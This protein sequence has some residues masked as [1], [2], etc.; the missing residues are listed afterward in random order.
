MRDDPSEIFGFH[1]GLLTKTEVVDPATEFA[2]R[3]AELQAL[4]T[5]QARKAPE[6]TKHT[7]A[8]TMAS[9][10][11]LWDSRQDRQQE[12]ASRNTRCHPH[13]AGPY[14]SL[15][16]THVEF[17]PVPHIGHFSHR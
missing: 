15:R 17:L 9:P 14:L 2:S 1:D 11:A 16:Q 3:E 5:C 13:S 7:Q 4:L 6:S 12:T 8:Q 10:M